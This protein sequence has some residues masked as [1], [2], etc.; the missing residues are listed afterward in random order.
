MSGDVRVRVGVAGCLYGVH[1]P[2]DAVVSKHPDDES[3][4]D[5]TAGR[6]VQATG[7]GSPKGDASHQQRQA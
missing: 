6:Q 5:E 1:N 7:Q 2:R 4:Q 3:A